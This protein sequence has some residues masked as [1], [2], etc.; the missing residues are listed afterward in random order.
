MVARSSTEAEYRV[1][2]T[3]TQELEVVQSSLQ[4]LGVPIPFPMVIFTDNLGASFIVRNPI[5]HIRLKHVALDLHFVRERTEKGELIVN[6]IP[7]SQQWADLLTKPL[8]P[9]AFLSLQ[10]NLI[11]AIG[12][13]QRG[14]CIGP[15][16]DN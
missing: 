13:V 15:V 6:H 12:S 9:K 1:I 7:E 2:G 3:T 16:K 10:T 11:G 8:P 5:V 14:E 4:K